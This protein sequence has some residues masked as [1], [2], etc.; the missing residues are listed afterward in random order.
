MVYFMETPI[1]MDDLGVFPLFLVQH[2]H[3]T[4]FLVAQ[5]HS[6]PT[7]LHCCDPLRC[8]NP[9][10]LAPPLAVQDDISTFALLVG[11]FNPFEQY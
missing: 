2:P 9:G 6:H 10:R 8:Q 3:G 7:P 4:K 5:T 11:G 1:K